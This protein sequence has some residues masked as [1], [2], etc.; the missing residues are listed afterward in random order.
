MKQKRYSKAF[1]I[2][3]SA[4]SCAVAVLFLYLGTFNGYMLATGYFMASI[5]LM[6]PLSKQFLWADFLAYLG[7]VLLTIVLG[8][9][10]K[11]WVLVPFV[12]FFGLHPLVNVL[13]IKYKVSRWLA[14][15]LKMIWFDVTLFVMY[16]FVFNGLIGSSEWQI[17]ELVDRYILVVIAVGGSL[18]LWVYDYFMFKIQ[19][20]VNR[21]VARIG[22]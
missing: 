21:L 7:T 15:V 13:Q 8:A 6:V 16:R 9:V 17:F 14:L 20:A 22:R 19:I 10:A 3:L 11:I 1:Q 2:T 18:F 4:I 12:M 5:A